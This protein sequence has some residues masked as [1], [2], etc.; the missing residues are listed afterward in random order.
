MP[1]DHRGNGPG[2]FYAFDPDRP[3]KW[4]WYSPEEPHPVY[5]VC[6]AVQDDP[7]PGLSPCELRTDTP[8][9]EAWWEAQKS[10]YHVWLREQ[11]P[12]LLETLASKEHP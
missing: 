12:A 6:Q 9:H 11:L 4:Q 7:R 5:P 3:S 1:Q 2:W 10:R 8:E